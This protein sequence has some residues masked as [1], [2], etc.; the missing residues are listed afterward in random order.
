M[1]RGENSYFN[2]F[3]KHACILS[4]FCYIW[5]FVTL[6]TVARQVPLSTGFS[7]QEYWSRS[8][9]PPPGDLPNPG[10]EPAS[11]MSPVLAGRFFTTST[12]WEALNTSIY[13]CSKSY[14]Y[15]YFNIFITIMR[16]ASSVLQ[17]LHNK[18]NSIGIS[19][20][21][22]MLNYLDIHMERTS[23]VAQW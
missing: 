8:P 16:K 12:T 9:C 22:Q 7:G 17:L 6:R 11:L 3:C 4:P 21:K 18:T 23:Q 5:L 19:L 15:N 10:A 13:S 2:T 1:A 20:F 14:L